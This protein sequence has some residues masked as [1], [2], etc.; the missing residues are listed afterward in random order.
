MVG[1]AIIDVAMVMQIV[2]TSSV[3]GLYKKCV[4]CRKMRKVSCL[5][6]Y[7]QIVEMATEITT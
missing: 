7:V 4:L 3:P 1:H 5:E 2:A 6:N